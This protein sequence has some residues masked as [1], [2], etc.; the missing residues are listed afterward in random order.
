VPGAPIST[1]SGAGS[2]R[3][4]ANGPILP[5][6]VPMGDWNRPLT[7][8]EQAWVERARAEAW[9][10][11]AGV[12]TPHRSC[13]I[14]MAE[15]FGRATPAYQSLRRGGILGMGPCGV[16]QGGRMI[17]GEI[18]GDPDPTGPVTDALRTAMSE[19]ESRLPSV[20]DRR[21]ATGDSQVC[22]V[23]TSQFAEF[24]SAE[25]HDFCTHL[26]ADVAALVAE[27]IVRNGGSA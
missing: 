22:S 6:P 3:P 25:R 1:G 8:D 21:D 9:R 13:G 20:M 19:Y 26:A 24:R 17:L 7:S 5:Y 18:F 12:E 14:A 4:A 10:L 23:L 11:Y 27:V 15:A 2:R 16:A